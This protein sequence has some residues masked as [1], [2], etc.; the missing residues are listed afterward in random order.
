VGAEEVAT[1]PPAALVRVEPARQ[2]RAAAVD[3]FAEQHL[4]LGRGRSLRVDG[5]GLARGREAGAAMGLPP[6]R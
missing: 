6:R 2:A 5:R 1:L 3:A 4:H